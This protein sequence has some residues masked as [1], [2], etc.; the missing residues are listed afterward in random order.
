MQLQAKQWEWNDGGGNAFGYV[1]EDVQ[2]IIPELYTIANGHGSYFQDRLIF[3]VIELLK[4]V[5]STVSSQATT[6]SSQSATITTLQGQVSTLQG[7]V[8]DLTT[9]LA[10]IE[11]MLS[12]SDGGTP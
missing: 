7:Q 9:R 5:Y 10:N 6:I 4:N 8:Q 1:A 2:A 3:Y 12:H 11:A